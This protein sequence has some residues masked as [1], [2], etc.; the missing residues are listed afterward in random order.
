MTI[1]AMLKMLNRGETQIAIAKRAGVSPQAVCQ[2]LRKV[3]VRG[4]R[5]AGR[6]C[7]KCGAAAYLS[8]RVKPSRK[9]WEGPVLF[10]SESR[11]GWFRKAR[12][13]AA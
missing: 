6:R 1:D 12:E 5:P 13:A 8:S 3:R 9:G 2:R 10:C 7:P 4:Y 11:C